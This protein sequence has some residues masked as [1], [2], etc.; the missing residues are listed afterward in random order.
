MNHKLLFTT[1]FRKMTSFLFLEKDL[2]FKFKDKD[3]VRIRV[4]VWV[5]ASGNTFKYVFSQTSIQASVLH[6][7]HNIMHNKAVRKVAK[8]VG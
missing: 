1:L 6:P 2:C 4:E 5:R 8:F 3:S 7:F